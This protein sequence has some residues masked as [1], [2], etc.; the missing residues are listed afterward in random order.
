MVFS[1]S[2]VRDVA[3]THGY[4]QCQHDPHAGVLD[5]RR[6]TSD[7][8]QS[9]IVRVFYRTGTVTTHLK[10]PKH[11]ARRSALH[12][13]GVD[14]PREL[15]AIFRDPR[16]HTGKGY[17]RA[18]D[19]PS[20]RSSRVKG[21]R[22]TPCPSCGWMH[23]GV[24]GAVQHFESGHCP[25]CPGRENACRAVHALT[26]RSGGAHMLVKR[27][28]WDGDEE[29]GSD[30]DGC[31]YSCPGCGKTTRTMQSLMQHM[32]ARTRCRE[33]AGAVGGAMA[34]GMRLLAQ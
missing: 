27:I 11:K 7:D 17:R 28:G 5:F 2:D 29:A 19:A 30:P 23:R 22:D 32:N 1:V 3:R 15:E 24:V 18:E 34:S 21:A 4:T 31:N 16:V 8:G 33:E 12:R 14:T 25:N 9:E 10:H 26:A 13:A 20:S 6:A